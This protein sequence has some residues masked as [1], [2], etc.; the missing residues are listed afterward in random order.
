MKVFLI[1][2]L[3]EV[4]GGLHHKLA[5]TLPSKW[6]SQSVDKVKDA[7][8]G[9]YNKKFPDTPLDASSFVLQVKDN[10]PFTQS[11]QRILRSVDTPEKTFE[12]KGEVRLVRPPTTSVGSAKGKGNRC[13]NYG[14]QCEFDEKTNHD[15]ACR[16][17]KKPPIFH[18]TRK[19]WTCCEDV[20]VYSFDE[21]LHI[22][23]CAIG[24]HSSEPPAEEIKRAEQISEATSKVLKMHVD[25][26]KPKAD[27]RAPPPKQEFT[28]SAPPPV[29]K[30]RPPLPAGRARCRHYGCQ[31][32][33]TIA[34]NHAKACR[35]HD[36]AP[37]FHEGSKQW[38]CCNIKKWDFDDFLA[39]PGCKIGFHEPDE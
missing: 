29:K 20:K 24:K 16:H 37:Y 33:Y 14:C 22:P 39:V 27:G 25:A 8:V 18:D 11:D 15:T 21:L 38:P 5:I 12:D 2:D 4:P 30:A 31:I 35:Y 36:K 23:G 6:M 34:D 3:A 7:F 9:A 1:Y 32:E 10:S 28:P 17:H 13:K 19:W 26:A